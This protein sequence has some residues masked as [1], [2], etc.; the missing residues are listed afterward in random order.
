MSPEQVGLVR[1]S[2]QLVTSKPDALAQ[3]F[4]AHWFELDQSAVRLFASVDMTKQRVKLIDSLGVIVDSLDEP[5]PLLSVLAPLARRHTGY[6]VEVRQFDSMRDALLWALA[7]TYDAEFTP[8]LRDAWAQAYALVTSV[9]RR[10]FERATATP[11]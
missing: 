7:D 11:I 1:A 8:E 6:G 3:R 5:G 10:A 9:M 4:Y 2:W